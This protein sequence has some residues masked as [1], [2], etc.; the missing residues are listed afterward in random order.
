MTSEQHSKKMLAGKTAIRW[1][2]VLPAAIGAAVGSAAAIIFIS[3]IPDWA[4]QILTTIVPPYA[5]VRAGAGVAPRWRFVAALTL[6]IPVFAGGA[7][8]ISTVTSLPGATPSATIVWPMP[9]GL[10]DKS[11]PLW[12]VVLAGI[13]MAGA[14]VAACIEIWLR[15]R[16]KSQRT[17]SAFQG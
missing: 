12:W 3:S 11:D 2:L 7:W 14:A 1:L 16:S 6:S 9:A 15:E 8:M 10:D 5:F 17:G 4:S 13:L